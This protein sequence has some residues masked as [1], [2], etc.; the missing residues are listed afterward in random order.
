MEG[1][2]EFDLFVGEMPGFI[3][4]TV[5]GMLFMCLMLE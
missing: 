4:A 1:C 2:N 3:S 5:P